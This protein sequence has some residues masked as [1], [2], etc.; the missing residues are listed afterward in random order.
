MSPP[1]TAASPPAGEHAPPQPLPRLEMQDDVH[2]LDTAGWRALAI[3]LALAVASLIVPLLEMGVGYFVVLVHE[4]GHAGAGWLFGYPSLPAFDFRYGGGV[5]TH[6]GTQSRLIVW[7]VLAALGA[8]GWAFRGNR[9]TLGVV[10]CLA[11]LYA[12][13]AFTHGHEAVIVAFGHGGE[14]LFA[15][16]FLQRAF[17]GNACKLPAERPLYAWLGFYVVLYSAGFAWRLATSV[18]ERQKYADAKGGGHWMDFSRLGRDYLDVSLES[19]AVVFLVLCVLTPALAFAYS[20]VAPWRDELR[21]R[22][23]SV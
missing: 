21:V 13:L 16:V 10:A 1:P 8:L 5:T 3:G 11:A 15:F 19:I 12:S 20:W 14:L 7:G 9:L 18:A 23:G 22:L 17:T 6:A 4:M 2:G